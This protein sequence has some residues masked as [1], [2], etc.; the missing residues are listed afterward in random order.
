[1]PSVKARV[2]LF[3][4]TSFDTFWFGNKGLPALWKWRRNFFEKQPHIKRDFAMKVWFE[5]EGFVPIYRA[6]AGVWHNILY[7]SNETTRRS[8]CPV[9]KTS[10]KAS[11]GRNDPKLSKPNPMDGQKAPSSSESSRSETTRDL[12]TVL[13]ENRLMG[14]DVPQLSHHLANQLFSCLWIPEGPGSKE[15]TDRI[16]A[17]LV[18][19]KEIAP[20]DGMEGMLAVQMVA[21]HEAAMECFR[22]AMLSDQSL[23]GYDMNLKHAEK[24][25][26]IYR[27]QMQALQH[28]R[29]ET[30]KK[31]SDPRDEDRPKSLPILKEVAA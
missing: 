22:R 29:R 8:I 9:S 15:A 25:T 4:K 2:D 20:Q 5:N 7:Q 27:E 1:M 30:E 18:A 16:T 21:T 6:G 14:T 23:K 12:A 3:G 31:R 10:G 17:A 28:N 24:L 11:K 19:L 26:R 13:A